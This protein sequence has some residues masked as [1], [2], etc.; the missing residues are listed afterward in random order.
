MHLKLNRENIT[1]ENKCE[2]NPGVVSMSR[3]IVP[4][5]MGRCGC[6]T[7]GGRPA[8]ILLRAILISLGFQLVEGRTAPG[9]FEFCASNHL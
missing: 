7:A 5:G 1:S 8:T 9:A 6:Q 4:V 2:V 3:T